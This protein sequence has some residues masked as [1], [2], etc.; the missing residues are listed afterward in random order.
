MSNATVMNA[1]TGSLVKYDSTGQFTPFLAESWTI[2]KDELIWTFTLRSHLKCSNGSAITAENY[3]QSIYRQAKILGTM[4]S[5]LQF[6]RLKGWEEFLSGSKDKIAGIRFHENQLIFEFKRKPQGLLSLLQSGYFSYYS[7]DN[8]DSKGEWKD[9]TEIISSGAFALSRISADKMEMTIEKRP[10]WFSVSSETPER[11]RFLYA[12]N[13]SDVPGNEDS[14]IIQTDIPDHFD[15][16][17]FQAVKGIP[18]FVVALVLSPLKDGPLKNPASRQAVLSKIYKKLEV[19]PKPSERSIISTNFNY[20]D[21]PSIQL[22][23][24]EDTPLQLHSTSPLLLMDM[25]SFLSESEHS[26]LQNLVLSTMKEFG[27]NV[28]TKQPKDIGSDWLSKALSDEYF[29][30][31]LVSVQVGGNVSNMNNQLM[32]CTNLAIRFPDPSRK[33]CSLIDHYDK[34]ELAVDQAY[35]DKFYS[36]LKEDACV[37]PLF[38]T[39][40]TWLYSKDICMDSVSAKSDYPRFDL[41]R[42]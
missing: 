23:Q 10:E 40:I 9:D 25:A 13:F 20:L 37:I 5:L 8:Y 41:L 17:K 3:A 14:N 22:P 26:F 24:S 30:M 39:G 12:E 6:D 28:E 1:L 36:I 7:P 18:S 19:L 31:R 42:F 4:G 38:H 35:I 34:N 16:S 32:F 27:L 11:I 15:E 2:S 21:H 33:I 29:D